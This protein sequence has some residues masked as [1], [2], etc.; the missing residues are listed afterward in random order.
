ML[1]PKGSIGFSGSQTTIGKL[2]KWFTKSSWSHCFVM[3][4][5]MCRIPFLVEATFPRLRA[6][7]LNFYQSKK[8]RFELWDLRGVD[9]ETKRLALVKLFGLIGTK[10]GTGQ[11][12][13][14]SIPVLLKKLGIKVGN[15]VGAG[16]VCSEFDMLFLLELGFDLSHLKKNKVTPQDIYD[17]ISKHKDCYRIAVSGFGTIEITYTGE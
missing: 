16:T 14:A 5:N 8:Q 17:V 9:E 12:V 15:P 2:I 4:G 6:A 13:S 11:L 1:I 7:P 3:T 10:Y